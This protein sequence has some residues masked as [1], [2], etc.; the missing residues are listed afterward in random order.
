MCIVP[1]PTWVDDATTASGDTSS[2]FVSRLRR[3]LPQYRR[4]DV[5]VGP[6]FGDL[7][8]GFIDRGPWLQT[9]LLG[10]GRMRRFWE[11]RQNFARAAGMGCEH[12]RTEIR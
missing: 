2:Y 3:V 11:R 4:V 5:V 7:G 1:L 6:S 9:R 10:I 12:S 8:N